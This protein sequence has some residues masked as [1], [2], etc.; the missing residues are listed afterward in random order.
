MQYSPAVKAGPWVFITGQ[1]ES[2][3]D[4]E[5]PVPK[6]RTHADVPYQDVAQR[7]QTA[8]VM[9]NLSDPCAA[10][11]TSLDDHSLRIYNCFVAP[12][13]YRDGGTWPGDG[14]TITPELEE[15]DVVLIHES[16]TSTVMGIK[17]L[18]AKDP[19]IEIDPILKTGTKTEQVQ[20][21]V[22]TALARYSQDLKNAISCSPPLST[23]PTPKTSGAEPNT[24]SSVGHSGRGAGI[25]LT[26]LVRPV[27]QSADVEI[28][29]ETRVRQLV[30]GGPDPP[31][32]LLQSSKEPP[33]N[34]G[35]VARILPR[36][37]ARTMSSYM[38]ID[39]HN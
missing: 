37:S 6:C 33:Q 23:P 2:D 12:D 32:L 29:L 4:P 20:L 26:L 15:R 7:V 19:I 36:G 5:R 1:R 31:N 10:A 34:G 14:F 17:N 21:D 35:S 38:G 25:E 30:E 3:F 11:R 22:P 28:T 24:G 8:Y 39:T 27:P 18:L 16:S 9:Q 13:Q